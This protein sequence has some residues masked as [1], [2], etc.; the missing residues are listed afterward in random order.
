MNTQL[1]RRQFLGQTAALTATAAMSSPLAHAIEPFKRPGKPRLLTSIAAYSFREYF[2][3]ATHERRQKIAADDRIS[4]FDFIDFC[5]EQGCSGAELTGYY[6]PPEVD[7][8]FLLRLKRHA[9]LRGVAISGT[10]V[11]NTFTHAPGPKRKE[12]LDY[13][14]RWIDHAHVMGAPHVRVFAGNRSGQDFKTAV[15]HCIEGLEECGEYAAERGVF[16]GIEN[17]GGIVA[18]AD[19]LL[20]II[21]SISNPWIGINLDTGN[22][23]TDD[24]YGDIEKCAPYAVNVQLKVEIQPRGQKR[25]SKSDLPRLMRILKQANYQGYV[26]LE[27]EAAENPWQTIPAYMAEI[28]QLISA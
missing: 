11:G 19:P 9:F 14:K 17:H 7:D 3:D 8:R 16:L 1:S 6:F 5:A 28:D 27:H 13:V 22:F 18:E 15:K 21:A 24:P 4:L 12:Q 25:K 23:H 10:A 2:V 26:V 20:E